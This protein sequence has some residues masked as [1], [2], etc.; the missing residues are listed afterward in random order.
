MRQMP[1]HGLGTGEAV[2][3]AAAR[4]T[5]GGNEEGAGTGARMAAAEEGANLLMAR[6]GARWRFVESPDNA[7]AIP[8]HPA[9]RAT[10][11]AEKAR[12]PMP[13][14]L[15][16]PPDRA[17]RVVLDTPVVVSALVFGGGAPAVLR[18]AWQKGRCRPMVCKATLLDL[19]YQLSRPQLGFTQHEQAGLL[20]EYLRYAGRVRVPDAGDDVPLALAQARLATA[21]KAHVAVMADAALLGRPAGFPC[22]AITLDDF[23]AVLEDQRLRRRAMRAP[24]DTAAP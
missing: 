5:N 7:V 8:V 22:P 10:G 18:E 16:L 24:T 11:V 3:A 4:S 19:Q 17:P 1:M 23:I 6:S 15:G 2:I 12:L 20:A 13:I 9:P 14:D 21:G